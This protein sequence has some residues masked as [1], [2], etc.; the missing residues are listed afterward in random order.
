MLRSGPFAV[1]RHAQIL[2]RLKRDGRLEATALAVEFGISTETIRRDLLSLEREG[3][4]RRVHGGAVTHSE[5]DS[6]PDVRQRA[7]LMTSEKATIAQIAA[8]LVPASSVVLMDG[9]TTTHALAE[10]YPID[11]ATTVVTPSLSIA[12]TLLKRSA[13]DVHT[14]GGDVSPKTWSEGGLWTLRALENINADV[15][16]LGCSGFSA[17]AGATTSDQVDGEV[18]RAMISRARRVI[19]LADS[20]KVG[21]QHLYSFAQPSDVHLLVTGAGANPDEIQSIS[22]AGVEIQFA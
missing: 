21:L 19:L 14:L 3:L 2:E 9:G 5:H 13:A 11:R 17:K 6:V 1:E 12:T 16:F 20:T 8:A 7:S 18:K 4:L 10:V 22:D 15:L